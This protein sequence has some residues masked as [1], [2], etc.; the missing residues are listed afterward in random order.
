[1]PAFVAASHVVVGKAGGLTVSEALT[2]GRPMVLAGAV[3]GN[4]TFNA[5][6]VVQGSAGLVAQPREVGGVVQYLRA[7]GAIESMGRNARGLVLEQA[8]AR[9]VDV[10]LQAMRDGPSSRGFRRAVA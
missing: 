6:L 9:V 3:P 2:A 1:M 7:T 10:V 5:E 8:S 4:E